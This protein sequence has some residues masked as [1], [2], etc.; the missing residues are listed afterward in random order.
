M[1]SDGSIALMVASENGHL[2]LVQ[3]LLGHDAD[4][5]HAMKRDGSTAL[6]I[7]SQNGHLSGGGPGAARS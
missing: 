3:A 5:N 7:A 6:M 4:P 2:D 1:K